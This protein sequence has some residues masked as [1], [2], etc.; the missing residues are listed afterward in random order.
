M[1]NTDND[2]APAIPLVKAAFVL[3]FRIAM[4]KNSIDADRY[5]RKFRLPQSDTFDPDALVPEKPFWRLINQIAIAEL[6]PDFGMQV[7]QAVPWYEIDTLKTYLQNRHTLNELLNTFC[8]L[9]SG[10][11]NTSGFSVRIDGT[12]CWF[13]NDG[14]VLVKHDIQMELYRT[15]SM[16]GL[17]QLATGRN[18]KPAVVSLMMDKNQVVGKNRILEDCVL[19]FSQP[20][21]A[22]AFPTGL[23]DAT[24]NL[25]SQ[26][27]PSTAIGIEIPRL[28]NIQDQNELAS[29]LREIIAL[30]VT[31]D[32]LS[33]EVIADIAGLSTRSLQRIMKKHDLSYSNLLNEARQHYAIEKLH[34]PSIKISDIAYQLGYKD[35]AHFTRAFKRWTGFSPSAYRKNTTHRR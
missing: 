35:A 6:I 26:N 23:L 2:A 22:I 34:T 4:E 10:Q 25:S 13:E 29:A 18:W 8:S 21:T 5:F 27:G 9:A 12:T 20:K 17:I 15:T 1:K 19:L 31:E 7:A 33:I 3:P 32:S 28:N 14:E 11:S 24:I 30:Y 16:I